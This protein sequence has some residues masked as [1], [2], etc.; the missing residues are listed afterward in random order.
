MI[1]RKQ[2]DPNKTIFTTSEACGYINLCWNS[3]KKLIDGGD[4]R[5]VRVG[6]KYLIPKQSIDDFINRDSFIAKTVVGEIVRSRRR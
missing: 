6:R 1:S 3:L 5:V 2:P 4:I